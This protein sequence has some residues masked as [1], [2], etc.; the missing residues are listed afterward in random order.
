MP[1]SHQSAKD[2]A[3]S[4]KFKTNFCFSYEKYEKENEK[5]LKASDVNGQGKNDLRKTAPELAKA[6]SVFIKIHSAIFFMMK[7]KI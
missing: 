3:E 7:N 5:T 4:T 6:K 2:S 1:E